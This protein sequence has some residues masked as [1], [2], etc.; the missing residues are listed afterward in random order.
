MIQKGGFYEESAS[1]G[2]S[3]KEAKMYMV[4]HIA[5]I[6]FFVLAVI[7]LLWFFTL[8]LPLTLSEA[9]EANANPALAIVI[10]V[11]GILITAGVGVLF[12]WMKRRFNVSYD[13][14][15][16]EDELRIV[17]VFNGR[18]RKLF[19]NL[20]ADQILKIGYEQADSYHDAVAGLAGK[21]P[22]LATPNQEPEE[23]K[24]FIY[25]AYSTSL[26]KEIYV[27]ECRQAML[28]YLVSAVG[29]T[30]FTKQ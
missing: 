26:G 4:F 8:D 23:G 11:L 24:Q 12:W 17:K 28:E 30:K 16:V 22:K 15:F 27:I 1:S 21:K 29:I 5:G 20:K 14:T 7:S 25:I 6:V 19:A 18:R 3:R 2:R 13:Y 10:K 9:K